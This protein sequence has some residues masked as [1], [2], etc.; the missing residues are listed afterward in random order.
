[1][2]QQ[3]FQE[4]KLQTQ[5]VGMHSVNN[6]VVTGGKVTF[7]DLHVSHVFSPVTGRV[8]R[9]LADLGQRVKKGAPLAAIESPDVGIAFADLGKAQADLIA[10]EHDLRRQKELFDDHASSQKELEQAQDNFGKAKAEMDR[11]Q[12]KAR[13]LRAGAPD[14]V[15]QEFT[16]RA[17]IEGEVIARNVNPGTEVQG[18]YSGGTTVELFT[19]GELDRVWIQ[20][21]VSELDLGQIKPGASMTSHVVGYPNRTFPGKVDWI[22]GTLD[23]VTRTARVRCSVPNPDRA[24]KPE[25]YATIVIQIEGHEVP[26]VPRSAILRISDQ[27]V[28]FTAE[29]DAA[30][31]GRLRFK[32]RIVTVD[33]DERGDYVPILSGVNLGERVVTSGAILLSGML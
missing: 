5:V 27:T 28:V 11:A 30:S 18:Q 6:D 1:M 2:T 10:V 25:M 17:P 24:L 16:L 3:Q 33:A 31:D 19:V 23:P 13:L 26:A 12:Q 9:I 32:R 20:A 8:V 22:S 7:D 29:H 15:T 4:A 14:R 21:D